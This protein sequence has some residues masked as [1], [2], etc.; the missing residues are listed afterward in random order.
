MSLT[1]DIQL[2]RGALLDPGSLRLLR[3][4]KRSPLGVG[5]DVADAEDE[6]ERAVAD[7]LERLAEELRDRKRDLKK[8]DE[9]P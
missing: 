6:G 4:D 2:L 1:A 8:P 3:E 5:D 9:T 7:Q